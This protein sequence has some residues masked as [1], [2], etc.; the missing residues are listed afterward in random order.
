MLAHR[1]RADSWSSILVKESRLHDLPCSAS[2]R[3]IREEDSS[4][5]TTSVALPGYLI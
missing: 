2:D 5:E 3:K 1:W 4:M